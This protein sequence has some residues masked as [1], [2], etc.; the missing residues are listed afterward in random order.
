MR[1]F[2]VLL[3]CLV[4]GIY[5]WAVAC[6][7]E[8]GD[9][10]IDSRIE[11]RAALDRLQSQSGCLIG[12]EEAPRGAEPERVIQRS[13]GSEPGSALLEAAGLTKDIGANRSCMDRVQALIAAPQLDTK[14]TIPAQPQKP[15]RR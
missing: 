4:A 3:T 5:L 10:A 1:Y 7:K 11:L 2:R 13:S 12:Y 6:T 15:S 9:T 8:R 14:I